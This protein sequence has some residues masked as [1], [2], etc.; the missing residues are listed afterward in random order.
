MSAVVRVIDRLGAPRR[1]QQG[2]AMTAER[3]PIMIRARAMWSHLCAAW[4]ALHR[5]LP[6]FDALEPLTPVLL[7]ASASARYER[8]LELAMNDPQVKNIAIT[9]GYGAGKSSLIRTFK[10]RHPGFIY[11]SVSLA[12]FRKDGVIT[13]NA[14][15]IPAPSGL[16]A[17]EPAKSAADVDVA[18]LIDRI[19]ET[20]VQQLLYA[21]PAS[22]LPR[23]RLKRIVQ[24]TGWGAM[25]AT[26][27]VVG[28]AILG[29][30]LYLVAAFPPTTPALDWLTRSMD[31]IS[32]GWAL[33]LTVALGAYA[34]YAIAQSLSLVSIDGWSIKGGKLETMHSSSVL[35]KNIDEIIYC[36]QRSR[37]DV[38][39]IEDLDRFGVQDVFFRLR[40]IN[41]LINETPQIKRTIRFLYALNDELFAAS[42]KT[43]FFDV[44]LPV[45]P[46]INKEN[47]HAKMMERLESHQLEGI[48]YAKRLNSEMV[49]TV[50][51]RIDDMRLVK[52]IVNE[53]DVFAGILMAGLRLDWN[54]LFAMIVIKNLHSDLYWQLTKR[55]GFLYQL[56]SGFTDWRNEQAA[57]VRSQIADGERLLEK[58]AADTAR[59]VTELR[60]M[61]WYNAYIEAA[62]SVAPA[63][64][65]M[66][67]STYDLAQFLKDDVFDSLASS[68]VAQSFLNQQRQQISGQVRLSEIL[69][70][71]DYDERLAAVRADNPTLH[72]EVSAKVQYLGDL[73]K[74]SLAQAMRSGFQDKFSEQ[75]S[76]LDTIKYLLVAGHLDQDYPDYLG[77]FYGHT[78]GREDMNLLLLLRQGDECDVASRIEDPDKLLK[79]LRLEH[80]DQ[81]RGIIADLLAYLC[82]S[83]AASPTG[84]YT[85]YLQKLLN[86]AGTHMPRFTEAVGILLGRGEGAA[87]VRTLFSLKSALIGGLFGKGG[88]ADETSKQT[89]LIAVLDTLDLE[90]MQTL[91]VSDATIGQSIASLTHVG[92]LIPRITAAARGWPWLNQSELRFAS[93]G[94]ATAFDDL[95][96][97]ANADLLEPSLA[98]LRLLVVENRLDTTVAANVTIERLRELDVPGVTRFVTK[99]LFAI[100][101][102][103]LTQDGLFDESA[104]CSLWVLEQI[105]SDQTLAR[106]YFDRT[107]AT[108]TRLG[109]LPAPLWGAALQNDR[110]AD[111]AD[112]VRAYECLRDT[113]TDVA[114]RTIDG[115][116]ETVN[117]AVL[118]EYVTRHV[119]GLRPQLWTGGAGD[120]R[121]QDWLL[122]EHRSSDTVAADLLTVPTI[123]DP[124]LLTESVTDA[125]L[126]CLARA[127]ALALSE[128]MLAAILLRPTPVQM[129]YLSV[130]WPTIRQTSLASM[131]PFAAGAQ[132][133]IDGVMA[134]DDAV[135]L[136]A[137]VLVPEWATP[138]T[139]P[140]LVRMATEANE[141]DV[142][143]PKALSVLA[144]ERVADASLDIMARHNLLLQAIPVMTWETIAQVLAALGGGL[145]NLRPNH[146]FVVQRDRRVDRLLHA[147]R[148]HG[149]ISTLE[150]PEHHAKGRM[151]KK[152]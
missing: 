33:G 101:S 146:T 110:I 56:L 136:F 114:D 96:A 26:L 83:Y 132:L 79:K 21:V 10:A 112:A 143:L 94:P 67:Y 71:M 34:T 15:D 2:F 20:I 108:Y 40:E 69:E 55:T 22:K 14:D 61:A 87:L 133:Y 72:S 103:L 90:Q 28:G 65:A 17:S 44:I 51:Y 104:G 102:E 121:L 7:D 58:K 73:Q 120:R 107:T 129:A 95:L 118:A 125:R 52:N 53:F 127:G 13:A 113:A 11:A 45:V 89:F 88:F 135:E 130:H 106:E 19:E 37:I 91:D 139:Q 97:L 54:K 42:E 123:T 18:Q 111:E 105:I 99:H 38:V 137:G 128:D 63:F 70:A 80:I 119:D 32:P 144:A 5:P 86:D 138:S 115:A 117:F 152:L 64:I 141:A 9:G 84:P 27:V 25:W 68:T 78:I 147:L 131:I 60:M 76:A 24:P 150:F 148:D 39:V 100:V 41:T 3:Y 124:T 29:L 126:E 31:W 1:T 92:M 35:H 46:V 8:E 82:R 23:T 142:A 57:V 16:G 59:S 122:T 4:S 81:G 140:V 109:R 12:T 77:H 43:K 93:L 47:S 36:F 145:E 85:H 49:E 30:R 116:E 66:E 75:L 134:F 6:Q 149:F 62:A 48:T 98:M 151:R 74:L 50:C